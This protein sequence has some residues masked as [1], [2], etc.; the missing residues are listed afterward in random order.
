MDREEGYQNIQGN[1]NHYED[2]GL[3]VIEYENDR[4]LINMPWRGSKNQYLIELVLLAT[5]MG[6]VLGSAVSL[7]GLAAAIQNATISSGC[8]YG[9]FSLTCIPSPLIVTKIG[10]KWGLFLG[11]MLYVAYAVGTIFHEILWLYII[12]SICGGVGSTILWTS[13]GAYLTTIAEAHALSTNKQKAESLGLFNGVFVAIFQTG[14]L[15]CV[16]LSSL[17]LPIGQGD[18]TEPL[19]RQEDILY[20]V[21]AGICALSAFLVFLL[22]THHALFSKKERKE[23]TV[24]EQFGA[25]ILLLIKDLR[26][27]LMICSN[28]AFGFQQGFQFGTW[29]GQIVAPAVTSSNVGFISSIT[30]GTG[31]LI[32]Y[33]MGKLA[34]K[35]GTTPFMFLGF[36]SHT[37]AFI[38][39]LVISG[40]YN[41]EG[42]QSDGE[43]LWVN[44]NDPWLT[45]A[46]VAFLFGVGNAVWNSMNSAVFGKFFADTK[47]AAFANL[48]FWSGLATALMLLVFNHLSDKETN[49]H[50]V[51][52]VGQIYITLATLVLGIIGYFI[53]VKYNQMKQ[54]NAYDGYE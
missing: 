9:A 54:N 5:G 32:G 31:A 39:L 38:W 27:P 52:P 6:F 3:D 11:T 34:D 24:A 47:E 45:L 10:P 49:Q 51:Q 26:M 25:S 35:V 29:S 18:D 4:D 53:A 7:L 15:F 2:D 44:R 36:L 19:K 40:T 22:P 1:T 23:T 43:Y 28:M 33:P 12:S 13:Q 50:L 8:L 17:V 37:S 42:D 16:L 21:Y 14:L 41:P 30:S 20:V 46:P 48:K